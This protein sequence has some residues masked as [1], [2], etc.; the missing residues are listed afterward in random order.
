MG[1]LEGPGDVE[2]KLPYW[3]LSVGRDSSG[4]QSGLDTEFQDN[5]VTPFPTDEWS[6]NLVDFTI[7]GTAELPDPLVI[8]PLFYT[9][10]E[11]ER[12]DIPRINP[13]MKVAKLGARTG[14]TEG[15]VLD[16]SYDRIV[17]GKPFDDQIRSTVLVKPGDS[18]STLI[19]EHHYPVGTVF[20]RDRQ[21]YCLANKLSNLEYLLKEK[22]GVDLN[23]YGPKP[24]AKKDL[25]VELEKLHEGDQT[26]DDYSVSVTDLY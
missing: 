21:G 26:L 17:A 3:K 2:P 22:R 20:A 9:A 8:V 24:G 18:G 7:V 1:L 4:I 25:A 19:D 14:Y 15:R 23:V 6:E 11:L 13:N 16:P 5:V 12:V 10:E